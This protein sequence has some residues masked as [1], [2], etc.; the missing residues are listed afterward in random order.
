[1]P[2]EWAEKT[3]GIFRDMRS[4][5]APRK[6][7]EFR[8]WVQAIV[9]GDVALVGV[10]AEFFT[11]LGQEI[12]RRSP[13]RYTYVFELANDYIGYVPDDAAYDLGGYQVWTGLHS[14]L[15][16]GSGERIVDSAVGLLNRLN[17]AGG[18]GP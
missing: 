12:K 7:E 11:T 4:Q 17:E 16:R 14:F 13:Y 6:G 9:L 5:L 1:M 18:D 8:T 2:P 15:E 3:I 10:P